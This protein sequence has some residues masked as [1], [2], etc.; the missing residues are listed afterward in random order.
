MS[1]PSKEELQKYHN[2]TI[3]DLLAQNLKLVFCG[4]NPG[5]YTAYTGNHFARPGNRFWKALFEGGFTPRLFAPSEKEELLNLGIGMTNII[6]RATL[7][8]SVLKKSEY[9]TGERKLREKLKKYKPEWIAFVGI[10]IYR[11]AFNKKEVKVGK[12][13]E[14]IEGVKV[15]VLPNTS[16]LNAHYTP[17]KLAELFR[18]LRFAVEG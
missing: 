8:A 13:D 2:K 1:L 15:W 6:E 12:Q 18:E 16:G 7:N 9:I 4:V 17:K 14:T 3:N 10:E 5:L 11:K